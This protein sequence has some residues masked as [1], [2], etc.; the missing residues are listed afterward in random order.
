M[1]ISDWSSDVCSSDLMCGR[2]DHNC[3]G[4]QAPHIR[5]HPPAARPAEPVRSRCPGHHHHGNA[6][7]ALEDRKSTRLNSITNAHLVCRLLLEKKKNN[8]TQQSYNT[9]K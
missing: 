8:K 3:T 7:H 1:R 5:L 6:R 2:T 9:N 4:K